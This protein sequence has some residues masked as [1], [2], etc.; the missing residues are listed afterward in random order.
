MRLDASPRELKIRQLLGGPLF[1]HGGPYHILVMLI[2]VSY[3]C[4]EE[5]RP[6]G[7]TLANEASLSR[8]QLSRV[9]KD[10]ENWQFI[11]ATKREH[12]KPVVWA[13]GPALDIDPAE[14]VAKGHWKAL[15]AKGRILAERE[16]E[17]PAPNPEKTTARAIKSFLKHKPLGLVRQDDELKAEVAVLPYEITRIAQEVLDDERDALPTAWRVTPDSVETKPVYASFAAVHTRDEEVE[18]GEDAA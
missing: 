8:R 17:K 7:L 13:L 1:P 12:R 15:E 9:L 14:D 3:D 4:G 5:I 11:K 6:A 18:G 2:L 16:G 10:L